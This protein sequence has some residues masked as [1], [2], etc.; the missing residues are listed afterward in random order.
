MQHAT[1]EDKVV[2][3]G[4]G[5]DIYPQAQ[6]RYAKILV[7]GPTLRSGANFRFCPE[8]VLSALGRNS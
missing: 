2:R 7:G 6:G 1:M 5:Y 4:A 3:G 8:L